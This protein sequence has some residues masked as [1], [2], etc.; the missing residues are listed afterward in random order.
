MILQR[1]ITFKSK[2]TIIHALDGTQD[3]PG[4]N[5]KARE[6]SDLTRAGLEQ[7]LEATR[8]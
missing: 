1:L 5:T 3:C 2:E 7:A 6:V 4:P 8:A